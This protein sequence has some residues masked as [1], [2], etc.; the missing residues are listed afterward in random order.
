[1]QRKPTKLSLCTDSTGSKPKRYIIKL[2]LKYF[3]FWPL[4]NNFANN[5]RVYFR[6]INH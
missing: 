5:Q 6:N 1:M 3:G 4:I 2:M